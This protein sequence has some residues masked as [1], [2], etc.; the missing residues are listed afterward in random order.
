MG[1]ASTLGAGATGCAAQNGEAKDGA[2]PGPD[3]AAAA[4]HAMV[5]AT[6]HKGHLLQ[7]GYPLGLLCKIVDAYRPDIVLLEIRPEAF[8]AGHYEDGPFEMTAVAMCA[9]ARHIDVAPIDWWLESDLEAGEPSLT[10]EDAKAFDA[11]QQ[12]LKE[13]AWPAF[14]VANSPSELKRGVELLNAQARYWG[15]NPVWTRRQAW[16]HHRAL[17]AIERGHKRRALAFVGFNHAPELA[18]FL[19]AVGMQVD[20]PLSLDLGDP[21]RANDPAPPEVVDAWRAGEKR[22]QDAADALQGAGKKRFAAKIRYFDVAVG[23]RGTCCVD[24]AEL[25][26]R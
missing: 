16:F 8:E 6:I 2:S 25:A 23:R 22:L 1:A 3:R 10:P 18:S 7:E 17:G 12:R 24:D 4:L 19:G 20:S 11:E 13:P 15:G 9:K 14:A 21:K 5:V 26:P